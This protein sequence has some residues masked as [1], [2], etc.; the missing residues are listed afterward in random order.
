MESIH[1]SY[2]ICRRELKSYFE[3]PVAYVFM[4]V[5]LL[6]VGFLTFFVARFYDAGQ[7]DLRAF[8][9]WHPWV[10]LIL[11]PAATMRLWAEERRSG[12]IE[13]LLTAPITM[14]QAIVG[15]FVAAWLF[16]GLAIALT[17]P[18]YFTIMYLGSPDH[19]AVISGYVGSLLL[20]A[21][22]IS[23]G[24]LTSA[25]T[26]NQVISFVIALVLCFILLIAGWTPFTAMFA[27]WAPDWFVNGIAAVSFMPHYESMQ[28][29]V[30]DLH[31]VVYY[32]S[33]IVFMLFASR[34]VLDN[35]KGG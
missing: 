25:L 31:D 24:M 17:C 30:I 18:I 32:A 4:I 16:M 27:T 9:N 8:F 21:T 6:L 2:T 28:R 20:A 3:S 26:D 14:V 19:G 34:L 15:K 12:T 5:F 11:V 29:G 10:F 22:Y 33:V 7:A 23:V 1:N 13:L 35:R